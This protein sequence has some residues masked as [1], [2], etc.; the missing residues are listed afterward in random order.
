MVLNDFVS[1]TLFGLLLISLW[2]GLRVDVIWLW[3]SAISLAGIFCFAYVSRLLRY[4]EHH[5]WFLHFD[6]RKSLKKYYPDWES[7]VLYV[8]RKTLLGGIIRFAIDFF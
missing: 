4:G 6:I 7:G 2:G 3:Y 8:R 5:G 1:N